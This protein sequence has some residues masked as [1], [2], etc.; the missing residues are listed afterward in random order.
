MGKDLLAG[1]SKQRD[2]RGVKVVERRARVPGAFR[3]ETAALPTMAHAA[4]LSIEE[5]N[6]RIVCLRRN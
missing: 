2:G 1:G 5:S 3:R 4:I 6:G